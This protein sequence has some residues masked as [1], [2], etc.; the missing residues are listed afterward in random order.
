MKN[1]NSILVEIRSGEG[2]DDAKM[3]VKEQ[4]GIYERA[5]KYNQL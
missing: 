2:G 4:L 1:H 5:C 3:L